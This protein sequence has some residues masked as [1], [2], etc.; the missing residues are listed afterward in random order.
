[1]FV[2]FAV[3]ISVEYVAVIINNLAANIIK[4]RS[5]F[6]ESR[7][8]FYSSSMAAS[9]LCVLTHTWHTSCIHYLKVRKAETSEC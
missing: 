9:E 3:V 5:W 8:Q 4:Y 1:M 2:L 6:L 7:Q